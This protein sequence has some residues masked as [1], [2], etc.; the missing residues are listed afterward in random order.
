MNYMLLNDIIVHKNQILNKIRRN[1]CTND[2]IFVNCFDIKPENIFIYFL[3]N[4]KY[5]SN[6][7]LINTLETKFAALLRP[8]DRLSWAKTSNIDGFVSKLQF[9]CDFVKCAPN[10][11]IHSLN[12]IYFYQ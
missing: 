6:N 12:L 2:W 5:F 8:D 1:Y 4:D 7:I 9:D 11:A 3:I 10:S